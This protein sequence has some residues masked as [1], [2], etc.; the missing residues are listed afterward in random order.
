MFELCE[1][2]ALPRA[3]GYARRG[4]LFAARDGARPRLRERA[5]QYA[6]YARIL[7]HDKIRERSV[8]LVRYTR[9]RGE[10]RSVCRRLHDAFA[11][12]IPRARTRGAA[13]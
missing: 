1:N 5:A 6:R 10:R 13:R 7:I 8:A 12:Y 11:G 2:T 9:Q 3:R 4:L